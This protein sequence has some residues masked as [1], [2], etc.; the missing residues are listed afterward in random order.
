LSHCCGVTGRSRFLKIYLY[1]AERKN[2]ASF[3]EHAPAASASVSC[4]RVVNQESVA[5]T[6]QHEPFLGAR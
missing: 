3:I 6:W 1:A 4:V 2:A 5:K